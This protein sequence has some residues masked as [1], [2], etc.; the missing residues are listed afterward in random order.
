M[1]AQPPAETAFD[2]GETPGDGSSVLPSAELLL[3]RLSTAAKTA[4][5]GA[6]ATAPASRLK[7][8]PMRIFT[9]RLA[10]TATPPTLYISY[11][12]RKAGRDYTW[13][14]PLAGFHAVRVGLPKSGGSAGGGGGGAGSS[15][16]GT[17]SG[18]GFFS[19]LLSALGRAPKAT[20]SVTLEDAAG[21]C[22]LHLEAGG[23]QQLDSLL[24]TLS[25][26]A[27][28]ARSR[29]GLVEGL[30]EA[31]LVPVQEPEEAVELF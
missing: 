17:G 19:S 22:L 25:V 4:A 15:S 18:G 10:S 9:S 26:L 7:V 21:G 11:R 24:R 29:A 2:I 28:W 30:P 1:L 5:L 16:S 6:S 3:A 27:Q 12:S 31:S 23:P 13:A 14:F 8:R 20:L